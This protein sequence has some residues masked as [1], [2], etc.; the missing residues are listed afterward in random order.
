M[1]IFIVTGNPWCRFESVFSI[2]E[3]G[4][5]NSAY[6]AE[7]GMT[8]TIR[9][10]HERLF[11][12]YGENDA[13]KE[14]SPGK[15]WEQA[16]GE[17]FLAN[18]EQT[19]WGWADHRSVWLLNFWGKFDPEIRFVL[20]HVSPEQV[21]ARTMAEVSNSAFNTARVVSTWIAYEREMLVFYNRNRERCVFINEFDAILHPQEF[22]NACT[23]WLHMG[24]NGG[25]TPL[26]ENY[27][28]EDHLSALLACQALRAF[29]EAE[30]LRQE[31]DASLTWRVPATKTVVQ[32]KSCSLELNFDS[33]IAELRTLISAQ[34]EQ[35]G[36]AEQRLEE[37]RKLTQERDTREQQLEVENKRLQ[38]EI[39][40]ARDAEAKAIVESKARIELL[41]KEIA[42]L[43]GER[44]QQ[45][46][47]IAELDKQTL[48]ARDEWKQ[49]LAQENKLLK[50]Q[51]YQ[52]Q[53]ELEHY[54]LQYQDLQNQMHER[55]T[56]WNRFL[57]HHPDYC[58]WSNIYM[59]A[60]D[61]SVTH[62]LIR[63]RIKGFS[64]GGRTPSDFEVSTVVKNGQPALI[65]H[66]A[67]DGDTVAPFMHWPTDVG[68]NQD[69]LTIQPQG[70][71]DEQDQRWAVLFD[72]TASDWRL[73]RVLCS[74]L[75][76]FLGMPVPMHDSVEH[77]D[78]AFWLR[79]LNT[80]LEQLDKLPIVWRYDRVNL[81]REQINPG[82]EHLWFSIENAEFGH[83]RWPVFEFRLS[84]ALV[85][86]DTFSTHPH[87]EFPVTDSGL[88]QFENWYAESSDGFGPKFELRFDLGPQ[89]MD[90]AVWNKLT[91][92][93]KAQLFS[94]VCGIP[95]LLSSLER[96][97]V[98][99]SRTWE[100]W[101]RLVIGLI[102][103][104]RQRVTQEGIAES[105]EVQA[106]S[107][108][109]KTAEKNISTPDTSHV[110]KN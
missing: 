91:R 30:E 101:Q 107:A 92:N 78:S 100:D 25:T 72:L 106:S 51:L 90:V 17:I 21:L 3:A 61:D 99:I 20:L 75:K 59:A 105:N 69:D 74:T 42:K 52:V 70:N 41:G 22:I 93:D 32:E 88:Q 58:D 47:R 10:W 31:I 62:N 50:Q 97:G 94:L 96:G 26:I 73:T 49:E 39:T 55:E 83:R 19:F 85:N 71:A 104:M 15:A 43:T 44:D 37:I 87:L 6:P 46:K 82:Y 76:E 8:A 12:G 98:R 34:G 5:V 24:L 53:E 9:S 48:H 16:A 79:Q 35:A 66:R 2:L 54:F 23:D 68:A 14:I 84:A 89:I 38:E 13:Q 60:K 1:K 63:W 77:P 81:K 95:N 4:G 86:P 57:E 18:W 33:S 108:A 11:A 64:I 40:E 65:F 80:L 36:L 109:S 56:V 110:R 67:P 103:V 45:T 28:N 29:P 102:G 7:R 27:A